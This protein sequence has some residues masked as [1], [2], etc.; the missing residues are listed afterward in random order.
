[1]SAQ[2]LCDTARVLAEASHIEP[3]R[4]RR[5]AWFTDDP[6][7]A[8]GYRTAEDLVEAGETSRLIAMIQAIRAYERG[9]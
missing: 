8:L 7:A 5:R 3:D 2:L 6:I 4:A 1:M 9:G